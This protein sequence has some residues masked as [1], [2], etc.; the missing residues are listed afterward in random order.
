MDAPH[1]QRLPTYVQNN[2]Q[3]IRK[4]NL[5]SIYPLLSRSVHMQQKQQQALS[6]QSAEMKIISVKD[7]RNN[8][9]IVNT[10]FYTQWRN[11]T[12]HRDASASGDP[13]VRVNPY[14]KTPLSL[15]SGSSFD[16]RFKTCAIQLWSYT[17]IPNWNK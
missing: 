16:S 3:I 7:T 13:T 2:H 12:E 9:N 11:V 14:Y 5:S 15:G 6:M 8:R 1:Q 17:V 10:R 4:A